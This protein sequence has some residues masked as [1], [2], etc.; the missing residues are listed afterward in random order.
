MQTDSATMAL[1]RMIARRGNLRSMRS[2][3]GTRFVGADNELKRTFQE[4]N[5]TKTEHFLWE[6][7]AYWLD[8][9]HPNNKSYGWS[10]G[11]TNK[12]SKKHFVITT[13]N[14]WNRLAN[15]VAT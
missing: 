6:K 5:H 7:G 4:M 12:I 13:Q 11:A 9:K 15:K 14:T 2:N 10:M 8:Q 1:R 3:N